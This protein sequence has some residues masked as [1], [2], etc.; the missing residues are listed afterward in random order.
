LNLK[1]SDEAFQE[2]IYIRQ[3]KRKLY[4]SL[5]LL[6]QALYQVYAT[7]EIDCERA[8]ELYGFESFNALLQA[9]EESGG[10]DLSKQIAYQILRVYEK[11]VLQLQ[12]RQVL[13]NVDYVKLDII[14]NVV[15]KENFEDWI[16]KATSLSRSDLR[17]EVNE[18]LGKPVKE[19]EDGF[20]NKCPRCGHEW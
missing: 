3:L 15:S 14:R 18:A 10:V 16:N 7:Y 8:L 5:E 11:Y 4:E 20:K 2:I 12:V 9:P 13:Q 6:G 17:R 1:K 19:F